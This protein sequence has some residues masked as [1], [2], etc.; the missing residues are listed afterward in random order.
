MQ[1]RDIMTRSVVTV[2]ADESARQAAG[3][4]AEHRITAMPVLDGTGR[5]VGMVS[6]ADLLAHRLAHD[7]R[8]HL[9]RDDRP[10]PDPARTVGEVMSR[11][12]VSLGPDADTASMAEVM[13]DRGLRSIP[14]VDGGRLVGIVSRRDL[15]RT[16]V[17][18]DHGASPG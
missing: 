3:L 5:L 1:A 2:R 9:W 13:L 8:S 17:R 7:P 6:E 14:I 16:L 18:P 4:L 12:V 11:T 15:L 10:Q